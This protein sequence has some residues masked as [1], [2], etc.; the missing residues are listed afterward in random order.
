MPDL[1][2]LRKQGLMKDILRFLDIMWKA[3]PSVAL[4]AGELYRGLAN[5]EVPPTDTEAR[6]AVADLIERKL[7]ESEP[8]AVP[9]EVP[10]RCY[11]ITAKGRDF[12]EHRFPWFAI[13]AFS[14]DA[15]G[16]Q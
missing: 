4:P 8:A 7:I 5:S 1:A 10:Q 12:V 13:D 3:N 15:K 11:K 6:A 9:S 14:D 2:T 16:S